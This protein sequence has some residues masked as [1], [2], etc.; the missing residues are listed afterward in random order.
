MSERERR[1]GLNEAVFRQVNERINDVYEAF[2]LDPQKLHLMC[3]CG[4]PT[5]NERLSMPVADYEKMRADSRQF[6]VIP[7][8]ADH[9][10]EDVAEHEEKYDIV[11]KRGEAAEL[12]EQTDP[13]D[14]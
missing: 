10:V 8:H 5:C 4:D 13:R 9:A 1:Q 2:E 14:D 12:A 11:R 3:E 7:G 6:A